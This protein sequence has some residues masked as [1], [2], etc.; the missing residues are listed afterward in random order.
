MDQHSQ[1]DTDCA[2]VP[3]NTE[4][5]FWLVSTVSCDSCSGLFHPQRGN[6][7]TMERWTEKIDGHHLFGPCIIC[8]CRCCQNTDAA[9][10]AR[11][12]VTANDVGYAANVTN[13]SV[14]WGLVSC[15]GQPPVCKNVKTEQWLIV[16]H[17]L[18]GLG[19]ESEKNPVVLKCLLA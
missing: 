17:L 14:L 7:R 15:P 13:V 16:H 8:H 11:W 2:H 3:W 5:M 10:S 12:N 6:K 18:L 4:T 1:K 9:A 19:L